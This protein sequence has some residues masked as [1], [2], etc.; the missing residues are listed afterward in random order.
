LYRV[1]HVA[2]LRCAKEDH[3]ML[4]LTKFHEGRRASLA[5]AAL[6][7]FARPLTAQP[8]LHANEAPVAS[9]PTLV[10][11]TMQA[12]VLNGVV[13][14]GR[15][16]SGTQFLPGNTHL[17]TAIRP[18][19]VLRWANGAL[20]TANRSCGGTNL[21]VEAY[22]NGAPI[23]GGIAS[24]D[25]LVPIQDVLAIEVYPNKMFLPVFYQTGNVCAVFAVWTR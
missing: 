14:R 11:N 5:V 9:S 7:L 23:A 24:I 22:L 25:A 6:L 3:A 21:R 15:E 20:M 10:V 18:S 1:G 2:A 8:D 4:E 12:K 13:R 17:E 16:A 19:D